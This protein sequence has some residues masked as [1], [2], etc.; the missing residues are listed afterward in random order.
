MNPLISL[1][2]LFSISLSFCPHLLWYVFS[3]TLFS[4][5]YIKS[6]IFSSFSNLLEEL[7]Y[8]SFSFSSSHLKNIITFGTVSISSEFLCPTI[9]WSLF[10][11]R[12]FSSIWWSLPLSSYWEDQH[13]KAYWNLYLVRSYLSIGKLYGRSVGNPSGQI[14]RPF[15]FYDNLFLYRFIFQRE[16]LQILDLVWGRSTWTKTHLWVF[17]T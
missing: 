13:Q 7:N 10:C 3:T 2:F 1:C 12:F 11:C 8:S 15:T 4:N 14:Y 5:Y 6:L 16:S 9:F 17:M